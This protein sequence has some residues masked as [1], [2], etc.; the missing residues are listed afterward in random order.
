[1]AKK[2]K[3]NLK[4]KIIQLASVISRRSLGALV[5]FSHQGERN[6]Y[7]AVG[8]KTDLTFAD[9][10]VQYE[11]QDIAARVVDA[12]PQATWRRDPEILEDD[13]KSTET[14]FEEDILKLATKKKL[15]KWLERADRIS[16]IG[17][18]GL[19]FI[20]VN[21]GRKPEEPVDVESL[22]GIDDILYFAVYTGSDTEGASADVHS[23][24]DNPHDERF[25]LPL[26]YNVEIRTGK[27]E[28][29]TKSVKVHWTRVIHIAEGLLED[30]V[31][32]EPRLKKVFD[33][34]KD[35]E[36]VVAGAAEFYWMN[37]RMGLHLDVDKDFA[38]GD[39]QGNIDAVYE[40]LND[41]LDEFFHGTRRVMRTRGVAI[42][43]IGTAVTD[44]TDI[45][46]VLL[47]FV[48]AKTGIPRRILVGSE[49]GELASTQDEANWNK[50]VEER[51]R[52]H[53]E[54]NILRALIDRFIDWGVLKL[55]E[56]NKLGYKVDWPDLFALSD[57]AKAELA[58]NITEAVKNYVGSVGLI[59]VQAVLSVDE[60]RETLGFEARTPEEIQ[61]MLLD[62]EDEELDET[63]TQIIE[64]FKL[65]K[66]RARA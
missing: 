23:F 42:E 24:E 29:S 18:F 31:H 64:Q 56:G 28:D 21:D 63:E 34:M 13:D 26:L 2:A 45:V 20:G 12:P 50:K 39:L 40:D 10:L 62:A 60:L 5:G 19:L 17:E 66:G 57:E 16:G 6:I 52:Q 35:L 53:A 37:S 9:Y 8:Y 43:N 14:T 33:R 51:Q 1:M 58:K 48:S 32:G 11:R 30:E 38:M 44:P 55:Q 3:Q 46:E 15:F 25:N 59:D 65:L 49:R 22:D 27:H 41:E 7:K 61:A 36:K 54:P 4:Q 47:Q